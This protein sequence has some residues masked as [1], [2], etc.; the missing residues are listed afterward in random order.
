MAWPT[1]RKRDPE[2]MR[3]MAATKKARARKNFLLEIKAEREN[4]IDGGLK[5]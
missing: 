2:T 1:G 4:P 3:K 5:K